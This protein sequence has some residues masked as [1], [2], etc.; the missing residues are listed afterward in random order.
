MYADDTTLY[1]NVEDFNE[2][3]KVMA[4]NNE[5]EKVNIWLK[6]NKLTLNTEKTK[7]MFFHKRR[8]VNHMQFTINNKH[9]DIVLQFSFL[10]VLLD[11]NLSWKNH[12]GYK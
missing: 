1:F 8:K 9:I 12:I 4:I 11:E 7:C 3:N 6:L 10:G 2:T 5:L